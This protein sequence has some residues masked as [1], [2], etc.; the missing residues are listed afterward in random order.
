VAEQEADESEQI[1][2]KREPKV[3]G[4]NA[5]KKEIKQEK[6]RK[7]WE[8]LN[9]IKP[10]MRAVQDL[11]FQYPTNI[12][13]MAIPILDSGRDVLASSV[14]GSGKTAAF[15]IPIIQ[16]YFKMKYGMSLGNYT[17]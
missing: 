2:G 15:L 3:A 14:T 6:N 7:K 11:G 1:L 12:Q 5:P 13:Q 8:D 4:D 16:R 9:L 17:K 10:I